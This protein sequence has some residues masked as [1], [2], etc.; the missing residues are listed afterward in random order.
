MTSTPPS[1]LPQRASPGPLAQKLDKSDESRV[2]RQMGEA[3]G[4]D[5]EAL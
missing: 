5:L 1:Q 3:R 4:V 2:G